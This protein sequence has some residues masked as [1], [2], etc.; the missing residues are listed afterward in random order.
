MQFDEL[1]DIGSLP[2]E[3]RAGEPPS[4]PSHPTPPLT[5]PTDQ[6]SRR[7]PARRRAA[8]P[9]RG[10][11]RGG[12]AGSATS[13]A[14]AAL[15]RGGGGGAAASAPT[16][17]S[18][19]LSRTPTTPAA[20]AAGG[21]LA[22]SVPGS[23][24]PCHRPLPLPSS[25]LP[26]ASPAAAPPPMCPQPGGGSR[27]R[28]SGAAHW[29]GGEA[30]GRA[31]AL[32]RQ[33]ELPRRDWRAAA[34]SKERGDERR[35]TGRRKRGADGRRQGG[36]ER[37]GGGAQGGGEQT[38]GGAQGGAEGSAGV[39]TPEIFSSLPLLHFAAADDVRNICRVRFDP[40]RGSPRRLSMVEAPSSSED[41]PNPSAPEQRVW[42]E[43]HGAA[44]PHGVKQD[45]SALPWLGLPR[46]TNMLFVF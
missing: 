5:P 25:P 29:G 20:S 32:G 37:T 31:V 6:A 19:L 44:A 26:G 4:T 11:P 15:A 27:G 8:P 3:R 21:D 9:Q 12:A 24:A 46:Y 43:S 10:R 2:A 28:R 22:T 7:P 41:A 42:G 17:H 16:M 14:P 35:R 34:H 45:C 38:G 23:W 40:N 33:R 39:G 36:G 1:D 30:D 13:L 18:P